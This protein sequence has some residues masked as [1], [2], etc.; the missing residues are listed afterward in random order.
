MDAYKR[1]YDDLTTTAVDVTGTKYTIIK[2]IYLPT[3]A[4]AVLT[5]RTGKFAVAVNNTAKHIRC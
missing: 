2:N 4:N 3:S 5:E 1:Y